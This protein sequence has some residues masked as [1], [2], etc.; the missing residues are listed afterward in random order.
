MNKTIRTNQPRI[1]QVQ[2]RQY[3]Q[4]LIR[5]HPLPVFGDLQV[6]QEIQ[7]NVGHESFL[8]AINSASTIDN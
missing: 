5:R 4:R 2:D 3:Q 8:S 1:E 7:M 6:K